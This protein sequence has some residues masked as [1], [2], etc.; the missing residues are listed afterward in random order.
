MINF[1]IRG[2]GYEDLA[3]RG[4]IGYEFLLN[5][6]L[7]EYPKIDTINHSINNFLHICSGTSVN[8]SI[9]RTPGTMT[10]SLILFLWIISCGVFDNALMAS[11]L[12]IPK[13][14]ASAIIPRG[15]RSP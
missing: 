5:D 8:Y 15:L 11:S 13:Q 1:S 12:V 2:L 6:K 9:K 7:V 4:L 3:M 14:A 10:L